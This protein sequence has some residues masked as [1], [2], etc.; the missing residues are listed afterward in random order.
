MTEDNEVYLTENERDRAHEL[1]IRMDKGEPGLYKRVVGTLTI[2][3]EDVM[4]A[5]MREMF[6]EVEKPRLTLIDQHNNVRIYKRK[7]TDS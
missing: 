3:R 7:G 6:N 5:L 4:P 1:I 2:T